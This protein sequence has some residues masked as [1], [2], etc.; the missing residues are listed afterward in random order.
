MQFLRKVKSAMKPVPM[1]EI[2][3]VINQAITDK[4]KQ[5]SYRTKSRGSKEENGI[6]S[7]RGEEQ[8]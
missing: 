4:L 3:D 1:D 5:A 7:T 2:K 6:L 8:T